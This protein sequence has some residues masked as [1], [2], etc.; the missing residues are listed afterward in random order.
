MEIE[1]GDVLLE[2]LAMPHSPRRI[3]DQLY[4]LNSAARELL[5]V[6]VDNRTQEVVGKLPGL[7][8]GLAAL[9][10]YLLVGLS[11]LRH[12]HRV[13]GNLPLAKAEGL[14]CGV[15]C[16][17]LPSGRIA[18]ELRYLRTCKEIYDIQ[19]LPGLLR[20][21]ILAPGDEL[22]QRALSA[23][24]V[25]AWAEERPAEGQ[26]NHQPGNS[27]TVRTDECARERGRHERYVPWASAYGL[28]TG[29]T[30]EIRREAVSFAPL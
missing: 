6:D 3:G 18:G 1:S 12:D 29:P 10:D 24:G 14:Y 16:F 22:H 11:Q 19:V 2:G 5:V 28:D 8:R 7:A 9:G 25:C 26:R 13:F 27:P 23:P 15:I 17:H 21:G 30:S 4:L 20:P